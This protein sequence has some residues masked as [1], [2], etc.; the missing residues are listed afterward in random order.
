MTKM[1]F[2]RISI[3]VLIVAVSVTLSACSKSSGTETTIVTFKDT[4][5]YGYVESIEDKTIVLS[6]GTILNMG[7]NNQEGTAPTEIPSG[8]ATTGNMGNNDG[9][10]PPEIPS[11]DAGNASGN[12][13]GNMGNNDGT[14]PPEIPSGENSQGGT[15][16]SGMP[17]GNEQGNMPME[18]SYF[19][20][21]STQA[22]ILVSD[23][24]LI[25]DANN[26][27]IKLSGLATSNIIS[28]VIDSDSAI[29][30]IQV[31]NATLYDASSM[32]QG[33]G[34]M[35]GGQ[36]TGIV[37]YSAV[38][39]LTSSQTVSEETYT[40][41]GTDEEAVLIQ[42]GASVI[43]NNITLTRSSSDSTGGNNASFYGVGA[44]LLVVDGTAYIENGTFTTD[45][46]GGAGVFSYN[47]GKV[48]IAGATITTSQNTSGGVHVAGGGTLYGWDLTV[49]TSGESS[50][51][52]RS[53]RGGGTMV[54]DGGTYTTHGTGSPAVYCTATI[55]IN[56]A[57]LTANNSEAICIEGLNS[58]YIYDSKISSLMPDDKQNDT[59]WSIILYQSTSGDSEVGNSLLHIVDSSIDAKN[60]GVF[61]TT[62]TE[63]SILLENTK[64]TTYDD[65]EFFLQC[66]GNTNS[67]GWG[68]AGSNGADCLFT[69]RKQIM[70]GAVIWDK[71]S[72]LDFYMLEG[73]SLTGA[74]Y[75]DETWA[76][77]ATSG[78]SSIYI[79]SSSSWTVTGNSTVT[80]LYNTGSIL[81]ANGN[82]VTIVNASGEVLVQ[83]TSTYTITVLGTYSTTVDISNAIPS[84]DFSAFVTDKPNE[85]LD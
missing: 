66:T 53:D 72:N 63:S 62:N 34:T 26:N 4:T 13:Q 30:K 9:T 33:G 64:I 24:N 46:A 60:G 3:L 67:R 8:D 11:G 1:I 74:I 81:D 51:A 14:N 38:N 16:P 31:L 55:A 28:I 78:Y 18:S 23:E 65:T 42:N 10:N 17:N 75:D 73:S 80:N 68:S 36:T 50:A 84:T 76:G 59:T 15:V 57:T 35:P 12:S 27:V 6:L 79:D 29:S 19:Y 56:N 82:F 25:Y 2:K 20:K 58:L 45:S 5:L 77:N 22:I 69:A 61:Y 21:S 47:N 37:T 44:G 71:A 52:I 39:T 54:I 32:N 40:S 85:L 48:Y 41:T 43:F 83:G 7:A 49:T 70:N